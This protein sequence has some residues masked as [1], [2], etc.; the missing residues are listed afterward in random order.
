V[1]GGSKFVQPACVVP[2]AFGS[3]RRFVIVPENKENRLKL[4]IRLTWPNDNGKEA[5]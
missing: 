4:K 2:L 1:I 5:D 3:V